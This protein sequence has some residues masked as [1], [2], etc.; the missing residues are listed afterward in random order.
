MRGSR[1]TGTIAL[2]QKMHI[3]ILFT[4]PLNRITFWDFLNDV[5]ELDCFFLREKSELVIRKHCARFY[6]LRSTHV[7]F[8]VV[9]TLTLLEKY[10]VHTH[11]TNNVPFDVYNSQSS[12]NIKSVLPFIII[13]V[14][15]F[16]S[17]RS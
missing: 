16:P 4:S 9:W 1:R 15:S 12:V 11:S 5:S 6:F 2:H 8:N 10:T 3:N 7:A 14:A 17:D 13:R